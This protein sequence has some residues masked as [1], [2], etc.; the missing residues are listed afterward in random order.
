MLYSTA[1]DFNGLRVWHG[2]WL[3]LEGASYEWTP[4]DGGILCP[5][6]GWRDHC[7][8][9]GV[10][11]NNSLNCVSEFHIF[12]V[13]LFLLKSLANGKEGTLV[14]DAEHSFCHQIFVDVVGSKWKR[15]PMR[16]R[17]HYLDSVCRVK[18]LLVGDLKLTGEKTFR[19][20]ASSCIHCLRFFGG[21]FGLVAF[22][23]VSTFIIMCFLQPLF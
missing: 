4:Q 10:N 13:F 11:I 18:V 15:I 6:G 1:S 23:G 5:I 16:Q 7:C 12:L 20:S 17:M 9:G 3:I 2:R 8:C 21:N 19:W 22:M 14:I